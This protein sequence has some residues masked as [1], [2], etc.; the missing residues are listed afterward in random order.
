MAH[1]V[2][3][4]NM[5][6]GVGKSTLAANLAWEMATA[7]W[8]KSVLIVDLDPQFNCSQYLVGVRQIETIISRGQPTVRDI[9]E[10]LTAVPGRPSAPIDPTRA[11]V[12]VYSPRAHATIGRRRHYGQGRG[13]SPHAHA[14]IDLI[15]SQLELSQA[16][17]NP[18]NKEQLLKQA[19][20]QLEETYDLVIIDCAPTESMLTTAAYLVADYLLIPV[21]PEFLSTIG[22]PLLEQSLNDF[23][24]RYP[25]RSPEVLGLVFNAAS[26]YSPE[27]VT[28]KDEVQRVARGRGWPVFDEE[29]SYSKTFPKSARE[30]RPIF[31]TSYARTTTKKNF[32]Q[33]ARE[34]ADRI[35]M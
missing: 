34:F 1:K 22:L 16:L 5:K 18:A 9:F 21:R 23:V 20:D 8:Y 12:S 13:Y 35:G 24:D 19:I 2:A 27:E 29:V 26:G 32:H 17:R 30:G 4:I 28:S 11:V 7:P 10:Q 25:G 15:P 33:F 3:L 6:G 14:S 31:W